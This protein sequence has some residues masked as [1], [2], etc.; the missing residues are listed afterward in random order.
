MQFLIVAT[1]PADAP[2]N[3]VTT[4][5]TK[6]R[7]R[8]RKCLSPS[9]SDRSLFNQ[10]MVLEKYAEKLMIQLKNQMAGRRGNQKHVAV[11]MLDWINFYTMD[12]IGDL[13]VGDN[14][15]CLDKNDYHPWVRTLF[16]FL[17]GMQLAAA[18]RFYPG[19]E[20]MVMKFL[21]GPIIQKQKEHAEFTNNLINRRLEQKTDRPDFLTPFLHENRGFEKMSL[22]EIQST[23]AILIIAGSET[24]ATSLCG[25]IHRLSTNPDKQQK[26]ATELRSRFDREDDITVET[27]AA[28]PYLDA[29]IHEGLRTCYAIP[30]G[31]PRIVPSNGDVYLGEYIPG[32]VCPRTSINYR[33]GANPVSLD[34]H[35]NPSERRPF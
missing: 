24:A 35:I 11:N 32:G 14:F 16:N 29:V 3:I 19:I 9:F 21:A 30:G 28:I 10:R 6:T 12:V 17:K 23:F 22:G 1:A 33:L 15:H 7:A 26:L 27:T 31:L 8:M 20:Q 2:Q 18:M 13:S 4:T 34:F 25:M 5:D